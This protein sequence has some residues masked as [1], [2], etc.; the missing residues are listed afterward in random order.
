AQNGLGGV[1]WLVTDPLGSTRMM[2][3]ETGSLAG[4]KRHDYAPFGEE[5]FAGAAI[6]SAS[7]GYS[8]DSVRQKFDAYERDAET[9][10]DFAQARYYS[11]IQ[12]RFTSPDEP[13]A[14]QDE[15]D[16]QSWN[17]YAFVRNNPGVNTDPSGRETCYSSNGSKIGCEGDGKIKVDAKAGTL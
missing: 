5:L 17:L 2:I 8:G 11:G 7:N 6:R 15:D 3:D 4:I 9:G 12:G 13:F 16:P 1:K 10:L 14:D